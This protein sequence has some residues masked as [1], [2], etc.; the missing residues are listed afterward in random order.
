MSRL[1]LGFI[2]AVA[3]LI[4]GCISREAPAANIDPSEVTVEKAPDPNVIEVEHPERFGL[5]TVEQRRVVS[6]LSVSSTV[7]PDIART[8]P[9]L[10]LTGGRVVE[11]RARLGDQVQKG[12]VLLV[13]NSTDVS[14]AF[15]D[16]QKFQAD[17][18]LAQRQFERSQL[19]YSKGAVAEKDLQA[20][21]DAFDKAKVDTQTAEQRI[22]LLGADAKNP[23][24]LIEVRAPISGTIIEQNVQGGTGV[25]SMD[26][27]P[28]LFTIADLS[29]VWVLCDVY[30]NNLSQVKLGERADVRLNAYPGQT[31]QAR[32]SNIGT[33]LD[34]NTRTVKVR[35]EVPNRQGLFRPGMFGNATFHAQTAEL[36][37]AVPANAVVRLHDKDWVFAPLG[38]D[39]FKRIEVQAGPANADET[40][41]ILGGIRPGERV[42][43][44]ALQFENAVEMQ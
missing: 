44:Q 20:A 6:E 35:L 12:Q 21:E 9:V 3:V 24:P 39:R 27:S 43:N 14:Q 38:G 13:I 2:L 33:V 4:S 29:E 28:N 18:V 7:A 40:R 30:E 10:S 26:N 11:V 37:A 34:P 31:F 42:V 25:K 17:E 19:L 22:R 15:S 5:S 32:I 1:F 23:T 36:R 16:Y 8:V 41:T